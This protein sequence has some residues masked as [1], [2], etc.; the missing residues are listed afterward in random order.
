MVI[1]E[2]FHKVHCF[3]FSTNSQVTE[4]VEIVNRKRQMRVRAKVETH[5]RVGLG[6]GR[7]SGR[8]CFYKTWNWGSSQVEPH[9][10]VQVI[11]ELHKQLTFLDFCASGLLRKLSEKS[12]VRAGDK[13]IEKGKSLRKDVISAK[14]PAST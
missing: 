8:L 12:P 3:T 1:S 5:V 6:A 11:S 9:F 10:P 4:H 13:R 7:D 2:V 14:A